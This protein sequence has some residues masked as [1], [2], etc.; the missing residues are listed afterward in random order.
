MIHGN[1][2]G[3]EQTEL[4]YPAIHVP[5]LADESV[6]VKQQVRSDLAGQIR[7]GHARSR[8]VKQVRGAT[9][10]HSNPFSILRP[11]VQVRW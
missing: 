3:V 11:A 9:G 10:R 1:R 5:V 8:S 4:V 6:P 7:L 2:G